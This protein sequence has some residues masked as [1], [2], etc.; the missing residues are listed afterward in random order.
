MANLNRKKQKKKRAKTESRQVP[1]SERQSVSLCMIV[2]DEAEN[3]ERCLNSIKGLVDEIII[4]DTGSKDST[5][6]IARKFNANIYE[7]P[8][9]NNF[10]E[11]RNFA[12]SHAGKDWILVLDADEEFPQSQRAG[13]LQVLEDGKEIAY[14]LNFKS[15]VG[16]GASAHWV[17]STHARLFKNHKGIVYSGRVHE[18]I[19][20]SVEE[21]GGTLAVSDIE[22][23]HHGYTDEAY[24]EKSKAARN[25][26]LLKKSIE[27]NPTDG[28]SYFYLGEAYSMSKDWMK[29]VDAYSQ[30]ITAK[31]PSES[32]RGLLHQNLATALLHLGRREDARREACNALKADNR[33]TASHLVAG[34]AAFDDGLYDLCIFHTTGYLDSLSDLEAGDDSGPVI[35]EP[36]RPLAYEI[37]GRACHLTN[38]FEAA[39]DW[40]QKWENES[41]ALPEILVYRAQSFR[42]QKNTHKAEQLL[43]KA[44]SVDP[45]YAEAYLHIGLLGKE[46]MD[47]ESA[48]GNLKK[49]ISLKP[50]LYRAHTEIGKIY[51]SERNFEDACEFLEDA[52]NIGNEIPAGQ[53]LIEVYIQLGRLEEAKP[54]L[55]Q[56]SSFGKKTGEIEFLGGMMAI[57]EGKSE[58]ARE[59]FTRAAKFE[60]QNPEFY[61]ACGNSLLELQAYRDSLDAYE[62]AIHLAPS[63]KEPYHNAGIAYIKLEEYNEA[64]KKFEKILKLDPA[65]VQVK[66]ILAGLYGKTGDI[67][68]A[69]R[70]T[71]ESNL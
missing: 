16:G 31:V 70:Y 5:V 9:N 49:A 71:H 30:G 11:A 59:A 56:L 40:F 38:N 4:V 60:G 3:L 28:F 50:N 12:L 67:E 6:E 17:K 15:K 42:A 1:G 25:I 20:I 29:A 48:L 47:R 39:E 45:E 64:I 32:I 35:N 21:A 34:V 24:S 57:K 41:G 13:F 2:K 26:E 18:D 62:K 51:T 68:K 52:W 53:V 69:I 10:S 19:R 23:L 46:M 66:K 44:L 58:L 33:L 22:I 27:D 7:I 8:W 65:A 61:Y 55:N 37:L 54:V 36:N 14:I 43:K 63:V